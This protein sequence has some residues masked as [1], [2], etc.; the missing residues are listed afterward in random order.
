MSFT[1][2]CKICGCEFESEARNTRYCS[3]KCAKRAAKK[4][5]KKRKVKKDEN[6]NETVE[7]DRLI[8]KAY[9]LSREIAEMFV[10]KICACTEEHECC[11][12]FECHHKDHNPFNMAPSNL[13]WVCKNGHVAIHSSE[14]DVDIY[15]E[16]KAYAVLKQQAEIRERNRLLREEV[17]E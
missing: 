15:S 10:P 5:A 13:Q 11:D 1:K 12:E 14:E 3:D 6:Y 7:L 17:E 2:T 16:L 8:C 4:A 9:A